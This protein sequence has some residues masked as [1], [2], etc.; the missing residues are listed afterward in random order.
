MKISQ[1]RKFLIYGTCLVTMMKGRVH[2]TLPLHATSAHKR[3]ATV[4][5]VP[6]HCVLLIGVGVVEVEWLR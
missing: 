2:P 3:T 5:A 1:L 4:L 6:T